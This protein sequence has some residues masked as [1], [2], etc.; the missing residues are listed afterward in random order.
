MPTMYVWYPNSLLVL[1]DQTVDD[2]T[3]EFSYYIGGGG[4][5]GGGG[6]E[7]GVRSVTNK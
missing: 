2:L 5:G 6:G 1:Q 3:Q 7:G 4:G